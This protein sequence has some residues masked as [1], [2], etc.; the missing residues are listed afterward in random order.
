M[1]ARRRRRLL[2]SVVVVRHLHIKQIEVATVCVPPIATTVA[3][4]ARRRRRRL[5]SSLSSSALQE[6]NG[7]RLRSRRRRPHTY[8]QNLDTLLSCVIVVLCAKVRS[9]T[10]CIRRHMCRLRPSS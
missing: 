4:S 9:Q 10:H 3:A 8:K 5:P 7:L 2:S 1:C 6:Q